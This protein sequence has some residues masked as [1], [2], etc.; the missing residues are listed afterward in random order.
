MSPGADLIGEIV[1]LWE[2]VQEKVEELRD[3]INRILD[4]IPGFLDWIVDRLRDGWNSLCE[5][6]SQVF[7]KV[8]YYLTL[9]GSP[10][11]LSSTGD[12]WSVN[13]GG[14]VSN[15]VTTVDAGLLLVDDAWVGDAASQ[16]KQHIPL[17]KA[18]LQAIK[19]SYT[20]AISSALDKV[21]LALFVWYG[22]IM[23]A[24]GALIGSIIAA[25][26][27]AGTVAGAPGAP[28]IAIGG[29][30]VFA[31]ALT[32]GALILHSQSASANSALL[33]KLHEDTAFPGGAWPKGTA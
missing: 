10:G 28:F 9:T 26:I 2:R 32:T 27:A 22:S 4:K 19:T 23:V 30:V 5:K 14:P 21:Q 7:E 3:A 11:A 15:E 25:A 18:A 29:F 6:F 16:Y 17:Q 13:V 12:S 20:D 1:K 31:A 24:L 33:A 8:T